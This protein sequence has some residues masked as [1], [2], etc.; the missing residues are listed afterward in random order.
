MLLSFFMVDV[1]KLVSSTAF[2]AFS[3]VLFT[4]MFKEHS[5]F[6]VRDMEEYIV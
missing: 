5:L 1:Y 6:F 2:A 4:G 3:T